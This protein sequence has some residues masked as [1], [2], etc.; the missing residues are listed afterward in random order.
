MSIA[1]SQPASTASR[2]SRFGG[3]S[4]SGRLFT[5]TATPNCAQAANTTSASNSDSGRPF[6]P[7]PWPT[8]CRP[9]QWPSTSVCGLA[10]AATMRGVISCRGIR[11]RLWTLAT[12]R[13]SRASSAGSWSSDPSALMSHSMPVRMR[14][15]AASPS[16]ASCAKTSFSRATTSSWSRRRCGDSPFA[17]VSR[18]EWS[19]STTYA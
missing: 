15:G 3:S 11:S 12:T 5:S 6:P 8:T 7:R 16:A 9:V 13:S 4:R 19:V 18:G 17:T 14:N 2:S 10:M 1:T